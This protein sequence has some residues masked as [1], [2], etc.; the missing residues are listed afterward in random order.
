MAQFIL[1]AVADTYVRELWNTETLYTEVAPRDL[2]YH[3][4]AR[5]T[6][7]HTL[8]LLALHN[9]MQRYHLEV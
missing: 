4:Q 1:A 3:L 7:R 9:K 2:F 8:N 5:C 6:G